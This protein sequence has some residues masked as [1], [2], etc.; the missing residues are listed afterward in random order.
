MRTR[1]KNKFNA[2]KINGYDSKTEASRAGELRM[3]EKAGRISGLEFKKKF[4]LLP[5]QKDTFGKVIERPV[6]YTADYVYYEGTKFVVE[7]KKGMLTKDYVIKR[8]LLLYFYGIRIR[9]T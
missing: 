4:Y 6:T 5:S 3:L 1:K 2:R 8:K 7:D 9:E